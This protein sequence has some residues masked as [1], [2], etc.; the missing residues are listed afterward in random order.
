MLSIIELMKKRLLSISNKPNYF[1]KAKEKSPLG[2]VH[3]NK[4]TNF[5]D[6]NLLQSV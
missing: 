6:F 5:S 2:D 4:E 3:T 1:F